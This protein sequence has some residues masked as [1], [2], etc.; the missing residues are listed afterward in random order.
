ML[1]LFPQSQPT[2]PGILSSILPLVSQFSPQIALAIQTIVRYLD[3][4]S[5]L[6][7]DVGV[8]IFC[9]GVAVTVGRWKTGG[10]LGVLES[11]VEAGSEAWGKVQGEL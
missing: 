2:P 1:T 11:V 10:E 6:I 4:L 3:L 9:I 8:L 5:I 7:T